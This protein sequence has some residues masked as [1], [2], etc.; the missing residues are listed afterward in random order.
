MSADEML[1]LVGEAGFVFRGRAIR[2]GA[3]AD[4]GSAAAGKTVTVEVEEVFRG[5]DVMRD[6]VGQNV[7]VVGDDAADIE[8]AADN[9]FFTNVVSLGDP[10]VTR[11][12]GRRRGA[13]HESLR[14]AA[15]FA[16]I[17]A[18]RPLT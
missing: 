8:P 1:G 10:V 9:V 3:E 16:R 14:D 4:L 17:T 12:V 5:T 13:S 6:L 7:I 15:E 2:R 18:E 11:E